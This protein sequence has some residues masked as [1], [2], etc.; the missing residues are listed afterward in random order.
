[1]S[2]IHVAG[3]LTHGDTINLYEALHKQQNRYTTIANTPATVL[4]SAKGTQLKV[5]RGLSEPLE[6]FA[7]NP[8]VLIGP[9]TCQALL[10]RAPP[11]P[12]HE[13]IVKAEREQQSWKEFKQVHFL[14]LQ[15]PQCCI[16]LLVDC[17]T[18]L[19]RRSNWYRTTCTN[20]NS[21]STCKVRVAM[22]D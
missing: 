19:A 3:L 21:K 6:S 20:T 22:P 18:I 16:A 12:A 2:A 15:L 13:V 10:S 4:V 1:L 9:E 7:K 8:V 14:A 11:F 5:D 17:L